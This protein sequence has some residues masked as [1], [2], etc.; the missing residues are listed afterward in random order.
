MSHK[1]T[2]VYLLIGLAVI[3]FFIWQ[4]FA[5]RAPIPAYEV[6][7]ADKSIQIRQYPA[8]LIANVRIQ[9][10]RYESINDGFRVL[11][12]YIFGDNGKQQTIAMTAPVMQTEDKNDW[13][14][15]FIMPSGITQANLPKPDDKRIFFT[16]LPP[17]KFI[18]IQF[19]GMATDR[20]LNAHA[21][22]LRDYIAHHQLSTTGKIIYGFY[23]PPWIL[24]F[25]RRNEI[26]IEMR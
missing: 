23:N 2:L 25:L 9:G 18:V 21:E 1:S 3:A 11:A 16:T 12:N 13:V 10:E 26:M 17:T 4:L 7:V 19:N 8:L 5:Y 14:I 22:H 24:P 20:N 6:L 15:Q